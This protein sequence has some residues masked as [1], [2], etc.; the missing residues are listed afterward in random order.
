MYLLTLLS[1]YILLECSDAATFLCR[2]TSELEEERQVRAGESDVVTSLAQLNDEVLAR[3]AGM[4]KVL[5]PF[6]LCLL[7]SC[8]L[9]MLLFVYN[10]LLTALFFHSIFEKAVGVTVGIGSYGIIAK[11]L[12]P[13]VNDHV[14][15]FHLFRFD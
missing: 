7:L 10:F 4:L 14:P 5:Q 12:V 3:L 9:M 11:L 8:G 2:L 13:F 1:L 15:P 6:C